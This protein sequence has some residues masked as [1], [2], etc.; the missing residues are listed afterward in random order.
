M[1]DPEE[2]HDQAAHTTLH[3]VRVLDGALQRLRQRLEEEMPVSE[4]GHLMCTMV[5]LEGQLLAYLRA[6]IQWIPH[7]SEQSPFDHDNDD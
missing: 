1:L 7:D 6:L 4:Y 2:V 5:D 3:Q